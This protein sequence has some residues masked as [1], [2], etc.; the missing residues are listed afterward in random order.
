[1]RGRVGTLAVA[2]GLSF[3]HLACATGTSPDTMINTPVGR[4]ILMLFANP[5]G[6]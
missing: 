2:F 1:M 4:V 6:Q 3:V 5:I